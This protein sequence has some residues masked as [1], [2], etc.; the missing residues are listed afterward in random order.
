[1]GR[2]MSCWSRSGLWV[3]LTLVLAAPALAQAPATPAPAT[4]SPAPAAPAP[5]AAP[6]ATPAPA[7]PATP[8]GFAVDT[9]LTS[10]NVVTSKGTATWDNAF[11]TI[12][13]ALKSIVTTLERQGIKPA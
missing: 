8:E 11:E 7:T 4:P 2:E 9:V 3:V 13:G 1:M 12:T 6:Q 5:Q 10:R